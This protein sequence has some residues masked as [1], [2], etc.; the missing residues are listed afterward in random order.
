VVIGSSKD[1][2]CKIGKD[3][4]RSVY[5]RSPRNPSENMKRYNA[6]KQYSFF[7]WASP[8]NAMAKVL[9]QQQQFL[10]PSMAAHPRSEA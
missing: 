5:D 2:W 4:D 6:K 3:L 9:Q 10:G 7:S 1:C 8:R